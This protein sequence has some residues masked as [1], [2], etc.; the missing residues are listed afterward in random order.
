MCPRFLSCSFLPYSVNRVPH[1]APGL[2]SFQHQHKRPVPQSGRGVGSLL[3]EGV[4]PMRRL[5]GVK[6]AFPL[7]GGGGRPARMGPQALATCLSCP[8]LSMGCPQRKRAKVCPLCPAWG[9]QELDGSLTLDRDVRLS[10]D[11][12]AVSPQGPFRWAR[13]SLASGAAGSEGWVS[14][15]VGG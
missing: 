4:S 14:M 11:Q 13:K 2:G 15:R 1:V 12:A 7:G 6:A 5:T 3:V 8:S 10:T 9:S